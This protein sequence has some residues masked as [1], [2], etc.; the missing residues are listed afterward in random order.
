MPTIYDIAEKAGFSITTVSKVLNNYPGVNEK[1]RKK[2]LSTIEEIGYQPNSNA[3]SLMTK[4]YWTIGVVFIEELNI[5]IKHPFFS[6]VIESFRKRAEEFGYDLL[7]VSRNVENKRKSYLDRFRQR[8]VD[9]VIV[10][11]P[12]NFNKEVQEILDYHIPSVFIDLYSKNVSVVN[13]DNAFGS[14]MA[15]DYLY[16]LGH[17]KIAHIAGE[18][19][20]LAGQ[21]RRKG[22]IAAIEK[23]GLHLPETYIVSGGYFE[24]ESGV[25]AMEQLLS[26]E[27]RPTAIFAASDMIALGAIK[28]IRNHGLKVPDDISIVGFDDI[29]LAKHS[30]PSLTTIKQ[31]TD[32]IG[33]QA[34]DLLLKQIDAKK[35]IPLGITVPVNL[36]ER[37]SASELK[38][39]N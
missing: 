38:G 16:S 28:A 22:F 7:L 14:E 2:I 27:D 36:V 21:E 17:R 32:L 9:G 4:K 19:K 35:K 10:V 18:E 1:T 11:S 39:G 29:E 37:E 13:S 8:G 15:V 33:M 31:D 5:G 3:R 34:A 25:L 26:L 12:L 6:A 30:T 23:Y 24:F 20:T